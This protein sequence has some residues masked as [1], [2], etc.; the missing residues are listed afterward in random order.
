MSPSPLAC[1]RAG[2]G[3]S[4]LSPIIGNKASP[5]FDVFV[6]TCQKAISRLYARLMC[7]RHSKWRSR[8]A[9]WP[10]AAEGKAAAC[11]GLKTT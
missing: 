6:S 7:S 4:L 1:T 2:A 8:C 9:A 3:L 5:A 11:M 10:A